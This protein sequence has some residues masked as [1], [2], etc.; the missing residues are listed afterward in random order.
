VDRPPCWREG[1]QCPNDCAARLYRRVIHND[2]PLH[3]PWSG[4]QMKGHRIV[5]PTG[6]W[7]AVA[8]L[9]RYLFRRERFKL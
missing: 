4:W 8:A 3:G 7:I 5:S 1:Q 9:D 6:E 2:T